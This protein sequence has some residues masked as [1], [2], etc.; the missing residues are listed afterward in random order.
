M[1]VPP[2]NVNEPQVPQPQVNFGTLHHTGDQLPDLESCG[3]IQ[4]SYSWIPKMFQYVDEF[5]ISVND[6]V[7]KQLYYNYFPALNPPHKT[8]LH[9]L[10][11]PFYASKWYSGTVTVRMTAIKPQRVTGKILVK[12]FPQKLLKAGSFP[13]DKLHRSVAK[14]WDL[15]QSPVLEFD[16]TGFQPLKIRPS[17]VSTGN[18]STDDGY[19]LPVSVQT[20]PH[21]FRMGAMQVLLAQ[22]IAPGGIFPDSFRVIVE[23][24]MKN[25]SFYGPIDPRHNYEV[26]LTTNW[27]GK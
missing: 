27:N 2:N 8:Q 20:P 15:S 26:A 13:S 12:F 24:S 14:E 16:I 17:I 10:Y 19:S 4:P 23:M 21:T 6:E 1:K 7:N 9:W 18:K 3:D 11:F 25:S 22:H 5:R